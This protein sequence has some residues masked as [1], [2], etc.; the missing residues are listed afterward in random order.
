MQSWN[1]GGTDHILPLERSRASFDVEKMTYILDGGEKETRQ[2]RWIQNSHDDVEEEKTK[3]LVRD[4]S[5]RSRSDLVA[6]AMKHFM[7]IHWKHLKR[8]Y[9]T[10]GND[11]THMS[12]AKFGLTGP[13]SLHYGV[14][15]STLRSQTSQEQRDWWLDAGYKLNF[16]GCYAQT[17]LGWGSNV[18]A[19][20]TTATFVP[21]A[22]IDGDGEWEIHTPTL[23]SIKWWSTGLFSATHAAL[24][25]QLILNGESKGVHVFF[26]QLR[27][28]DLT[29][30][31]GI[32]MGDI[33]RKIGD[34][35]TPIGYLRLNKG[36]VREC[37]SY[38]SLTHIHN[39][40][41]QFAFLDGI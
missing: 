20:K 19:L 25:A 22:G 5:D 34:N 38:Y 23:R 33:G 39:P 12:A 14:F 37:Q 10:S 35:D 21:G 40:N 15:M 13:L 3:N 31:K 6:D 4:D 2:R 11:M 16:I 27:G 9:K 32:E 28:P 8:G 1:N 18:R 26:V 30:L 36:T 41:I 7:D 24:Y 17:E 29:P